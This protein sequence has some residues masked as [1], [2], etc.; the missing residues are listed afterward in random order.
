M[1]SAIV[2][3]CSVIL[4]LLGIY[5]KINDKKEIRK[6]ETKDAVYSGDIGRINAIIQRLYNK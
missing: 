2:A 4:A 3:I 6:K 5:A 1:W